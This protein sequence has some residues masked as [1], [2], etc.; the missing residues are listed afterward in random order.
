MV[1]TIDDPQRRNPD[2]VRAVLAGRSKAFPLPAA[3]ALLPDL[4][5]PVSER[6]DLLGDVVGSA[7]DAT[8]RVAAAIGLRRLR[9]PGAR[10]RLRAALEGEAES[11]VVADVALALGFVGAEED[12]RRLSEKAERVKEGW[13]R[14]RIAFAAALIAHRTGLPE[15]DLRFPP[16]D[17]VLRVEQADAGVASRRPEGREVSLALD[18]LETEPVG[19]ASAAEQVH[20]IECGPRTLYVALDREVASDLGRLRERKG[21][22][23]VVE[24]F[25]EEHGRAAPA[26]LVLTDPADANVDLFVT[27][28]T[29]EPLYRGKASL[30]GARLDAKLWSVDAAGVTPVELHVTLEGNEVSVQGSSDSTVRKQRHATPMR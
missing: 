5:V 27:R 20:V 26:M 18:A 28:L 15:P 17:A 11:R 29:G 30:D 8:A 19:I 23:G 25:Y 9:T 16:A 7:D 4:D 14:D 12:V 24:T 21:M 6:E 22:L 3:V 1:A 2:V 10:D 13:A